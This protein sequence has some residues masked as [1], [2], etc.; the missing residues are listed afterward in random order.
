MSAGEQHKLICVPLLFG[1]IT[2]HPV[3]MSRLL[4]AHFPSRKL[5]PADKNASNSPTRQLANPLRWSAPTE[6]PLGGHPGWAEWYAILLC[7]RK[8]QSRRVVTLNRWLC[9]KTADGRATCLCLYLC[10]CLSLS[11]MLL[12]LHS[13]SDPGSPFTAR[14]CSSTHIHSWRAGDA[15]E[16]SQ[17]VDRRRSSAIQRR[18]HGTL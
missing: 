4:M 8:W 7:S 2:P 13:S 11:F 18:R 12:S 17:A 1:V 3:T 14:M 16:Y 15:R 5:S 10:E 9:G 6:N